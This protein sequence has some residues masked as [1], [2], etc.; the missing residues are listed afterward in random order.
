MKSTYDPHDDP[1]PKE[2]LS[3]DE[4]I[5]SMLVEEYHQEAGI[6]LPNLR[7]HALIHV[8]VENQV[9]MA[10]ETPV[11]RT[12]NRLIEEGL[13]RHDAIHAI[14]SILAKQI[15]NLFNEKPESGFSDSAYRQDLERL[16]AESWSRGDW[17]K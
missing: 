1:D 4:G 10:D 11:Q 6:K 5:R 3:L 7:L 12:L 8:V 2:W 13:D 17:T 9:A 14:G 16:T 15:Y